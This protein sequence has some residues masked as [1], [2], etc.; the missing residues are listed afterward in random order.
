MPSAIAVFVAI[1]IDRLAIKS[2]LDMQSVGLYAIGYRVAAIV[3]LL[4][5]GFQSALTPLVFN[6]LDNSNTP[7]EIARIFRFFLA[8][9]L[10][11]LVFIILFSKEL[12]EFITTPAYFKAYSVIPL[13]GAATLLSNMYIF[14]P[15]LFIAKKTSHI[16]GI[17]IF[18]ATLNICLNFLLIPHLGINGAALATSEQFSNQFHIIHVI[19]PETL[20]STPSMEKNIF[21]NS[22]N[23]ASTC[24]SYS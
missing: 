2:L 11:L 23:H 12:L 4:L 22:R 6:D 14:A 17:N 13:L 9:V 10:P 15:G 21:G 18:T 16:A 1:Y 5:F 7:N 8:L 20:S 24:N 3:S 19:Q